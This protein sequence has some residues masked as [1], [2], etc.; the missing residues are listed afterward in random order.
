VLRDAG[1]IAPAPDP[2]ALQARLAHLFRHSAGDDA[3][4]RATGI[5][6]RYM[7]DYRLGREIAP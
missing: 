6:H 7:E 2:A 1:S 4:G 3:A 5:L